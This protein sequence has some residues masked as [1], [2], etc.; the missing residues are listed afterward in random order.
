MLSIVL[1][2]VLAILIVST[3]FV[4]VRTIVFQRSQRSVEPVEGV[5]VDDQRVAEHLAA[6]VRC[7]TAPLD[8]TGTPDP[9]SFQ[10]LH[11]MLEDTYPQ[12]HRKLRREVVNGY[13]LLYTCRAAGPTLSR[14]C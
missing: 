2:L 13:S 3:A 4:V 12:V 5:P 6:A 1:Y 8:D 7:R 14:S 10:Q 11:R 9:Q